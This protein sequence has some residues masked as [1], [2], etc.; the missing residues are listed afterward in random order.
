MGYGI[1]QL[2]WVGND[3]GRVGEILDLG[4]YAFRVF[5]MGIGEAGEDENG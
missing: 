2:G 3:V 5:G 4:E 1:V